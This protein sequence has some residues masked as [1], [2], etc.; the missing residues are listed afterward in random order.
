MN[1]IIFEFSQFFLPHAGYRL[2]LAG[3]KSWVPNLSLGP[4][5]P[6]PPLLLFMLQIPLVNHYGHS[7]VNRTD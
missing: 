4:R 3:L 2:L 5:P 7:W 1:M 6:R